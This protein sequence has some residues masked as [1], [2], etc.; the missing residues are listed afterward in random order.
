[1]SP[2]DE[3]LAAADAVLVGHDPDDTQM[4]SAAGWSRLFRAEAALPIP[5]ASVL[6]VARVINVVRGE[7]R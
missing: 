5:S 2:A 7:G 3:L 4:G 1:V 6:E